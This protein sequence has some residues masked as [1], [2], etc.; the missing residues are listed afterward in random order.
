MTLYETRIT[1]PTWSNSHD[2]QSRSIRL[3]HFLMLKAAVPARTTTD[4]SRRLLY[5][6]IFCGGIFHHPICGPVTFPLQ[7]LFPGNPV[8][9]PGPAMP[10]VYGMPPPPLVPPF[11]RWLP[12]VLTHA[13]DT[14][15]SLSQAVFALS[16]SRIFQISVAWKVR[17][18]SGTISRPRLQATR[19]ASFAC[20]S[21]GLHQGRPRLRGSNLQS[22]CVP[23]TAQHLNLQQGVKWTQLECL[24]GFGPVLTARILFHHRK[25]T[26]SKLRVDANW[27]HLQ[28]CRSD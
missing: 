21:P 23:H 7:G 12:L 24:V 13:S 14:M 4:P 28:G 10:G 17:P 27:M 5:H 9:F 20:G 11:G 26:D 1:L 15:H 3:K 6:S 8:A 2:Q 22:R 19:G 25:T 18:P 16:H